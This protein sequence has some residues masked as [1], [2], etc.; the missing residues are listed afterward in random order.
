MDD[1][2]LLVK[3]VFQTLKKSGQ[4][5]EFSLTLQFS[6]LRPRDAAASRGLDT[7]HFL[8]V[9]GNNILVLWIKRQQTSE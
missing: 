2:P 5:T 4:Q 3:P 9:S 8:E 7:F 1:K 6:F